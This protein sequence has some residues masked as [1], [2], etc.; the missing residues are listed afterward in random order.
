MTGEFALREH[1]A[2]VAVEATGGS[3]AAVFAAV[4]DGLAAAQCD[5]V[6]ATG[7]EQF[8]V[9]REAEDLDGLLYDYLGRLIYE[10]DVRGVLPVDNDVTITPLVDER[11]GDVDGV[12]DSDGDVEG[13]DD[14]DGDVDGVDDSDGDVDGV[15]GSDASGADDVGRE[16]HRYRLDATARG[17]DLADVDAREVKAV[18]F[19]QMVVEE[20]DGEWYAYVVFDV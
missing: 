12:D 10:R 14:S 18:T 6:P 15:D 1:T 17:V 13:I 5:D 2:D 16:G 7:G 19:S 11:D 9:E 8:R 4:A 3:M 20:R